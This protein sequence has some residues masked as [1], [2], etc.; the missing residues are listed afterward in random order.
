[1]ERNE[2]DLRLRVTRREHADLGKL[3]DWVL[4]IAETRHQAWQRSEP[5]PYDLPLPSELTSAGRSS[6]P[7]AFFLS[8]VREKIEAKQHPRRGGPP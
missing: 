1:M 2:R 4:N 8:E 3:I 5:D 6:T 7:E